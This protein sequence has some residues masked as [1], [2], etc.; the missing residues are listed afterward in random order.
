MKDKR[1]DEQAEEQRRAH[2]DRGFGHHLPVRLAAQRL[3]RM[4]VLPGLDL[5]VRVLDH[6]DGRVHHRADGDGDA[7][8]RHDVGV[9]ALVA[10]SPRR[11][12]ARRSA[13]R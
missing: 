3:A 10:A 1:D 9:D 13:A 6:H 11:Q 4:G 7:A 5:L 2:F 8:E 12:S